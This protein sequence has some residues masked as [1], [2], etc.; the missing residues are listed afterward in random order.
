MKKKRNSRNVQLFSEVGR[1]LKSKKDSKKAL[2][3]VN[4]GV[5]H[6]STAEDA[7]TELLGRI[8]T[9]LQGIQPTERYGLTAP[10]KKTSV[11]T[12]LIAIR[13]PKS[14]HDELKALGGLKSRHV[15]RAIMLYLKAMKTGKGDIGA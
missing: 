7:D 6:R 8:R 4:N 11:P 10:G 13:I 14:L 5:I 12:E 3:S 1:R 15:E 2:Q 9:M